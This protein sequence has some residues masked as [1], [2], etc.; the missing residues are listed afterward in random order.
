MWH[1]KLEVSGYTVIKKS[2]HAFSLFFGQNDVKLLDSL[3]LM[4]CVTCFHLQPHAV[5]LP[6]SFSDQNNFELQ[7]IAECLKAGSFKWC[8]HGAAS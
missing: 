7:K 3:T 8:F 6:K 5:T 4:T 2:I 1:L